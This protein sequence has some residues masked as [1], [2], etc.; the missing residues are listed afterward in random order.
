MCQECMEHIFLYKVED[1]GAKLG[2]NLS[3]KFL[4]GKVL[5][6]KVNEF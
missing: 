5:E 4:K 3:G 1:F 2:I 6:E